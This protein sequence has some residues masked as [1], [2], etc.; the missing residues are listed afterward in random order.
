METMYPYNWPILSTTHAA[1]AQELRPVSWWT[2]QGSVNANGSVRNL[3]VTSLNIITCSS[4][5]F[6]TLTDLY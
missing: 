4:K 5:N 1:D 6:I 2:R 3:D